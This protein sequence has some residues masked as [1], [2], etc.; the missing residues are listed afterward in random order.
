MDKAELS[1]ISDA[2]PLGELLLAMQASGH[3]AALVQ[4]AQGLRMLTADQAFRTLQRRGWAPTAARDVEALLP[5]TFLPPRS[6]D[7]DWIRRPEVSQGL[8]YAL[9]S[10]E[11]KYAVLRATDRQA[12]VMTAD[13]LMA[14]AFNMRIALCRCKQHPQTHVFRPHELDPSGHCPLDD[15]A[16]DCG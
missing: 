5:P 7:A 16:V 15:S 3:A 2:T 6:A 8:A 4:T 12:L 9:G 13:P 1:I 14:E 11:G 10:G